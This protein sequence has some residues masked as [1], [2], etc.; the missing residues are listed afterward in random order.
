MSYFA[1]SFSQKELPDFGRIVKLLRAFQKKDKCP[2]FN[3]N[4]CDIIAQQTV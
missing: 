4:I 3:E 2:F 1:R